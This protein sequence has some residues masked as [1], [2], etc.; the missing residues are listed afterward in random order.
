MRVEVKKALKKTQCTP[1]LPSNITREE[2]KALKELK[3]DKS[4]I[5]MTVD[6][7]VALVIMDK[8]EYNKKAEDLLNAKTYK[9][10]LEDPINK[11]KNR[12]ISILKN[13]KAEGGLTEE[14]YRRLYPTG[15]VSPK[16]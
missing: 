1:R 4:R 2:Y 7:G 16:F 14:V 6:N 11:Q 12:L 13:I 3:E 10:I 15:A 5:I 8:A 9:K